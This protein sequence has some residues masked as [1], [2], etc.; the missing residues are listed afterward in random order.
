MIE[1]QAFAAAAVALASITS[2][3]RDGACTLLA[4]ELHTFARESLR[5]HKSEHYEGA[6]LATT[7][8]CIYCSA[9][10]KSIEEQFTLQDC[11]Y[12]LQATTFNSVPDGV[13]SA[14]FWAFARQGTKLYNSNGLNLMNL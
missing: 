14:C 2:L 13:F 7:L 9:V 4:R 3:R 1:S 6:L 8:L 11:A 10:E 12:L 5:R